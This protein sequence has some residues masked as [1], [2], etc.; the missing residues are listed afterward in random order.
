[1]VAWDRDYCVGILQGLAS[2][3]VLSSAIGSPKGS[4]PLAEVKMIVT[5]EIDIPEKKYNG[6]CRAYVINVPRPSSKL[7]PSFPGN[8]IL[9]ASLLEAWKHHTKV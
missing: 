9:S 8:G 7:G 4:R 5:E 2:R 6:L 1:M 3:S